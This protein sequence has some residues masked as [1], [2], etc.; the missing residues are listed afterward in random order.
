MPSAPWTDPSYLAAGIAQTHFA[1]ALTSGK[2][3]TVTDSATGRVY[4]IRGSRLIQ[5]ASGVPQAYPTS[6]TD[7][8]ALASTTT[9]GI[10]LVIDFHMHWNS[11]AQTI[12]GSSGV[13]EVV[14]AD[15]H[16]IGDGAV[17]ATFE[18]HDEYW[19]RTPSP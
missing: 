9:D 3:Y 7:G 12:N 15:V 1:P 10:P 5:D 8:H 11:S 2:P 17:H 19:T 13:F 16:Q 18:K 14:S 4:P 6:A